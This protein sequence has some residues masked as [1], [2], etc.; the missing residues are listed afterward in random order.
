MRHKPVPGRDLGVHAGLE[1]ALRAALFFLQLFEVLD[2]CAVPFS[3]W[4]S[5][6][7][8]HLTSLSSSTPLPN[9]PQS[10]PGNPMRASSTF[11]ISIENPRGARGM[12]SWH[13]QVNGGFTQPD[14]ALPFSE[15]VGT[16][17]TSNSRL[18]TLVKPPN[19]QDG[20]QKRVKDEGNLEWNDN[21]V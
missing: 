5:V 13:S 12:S 15:R 16:L 14:W 8:S 6:W 19:S 20:N 21:A 4:E 18:S 7:W 3:T 10:W 17:P 2:L 11:F 9:P 1:Q